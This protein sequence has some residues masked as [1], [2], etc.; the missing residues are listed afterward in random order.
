MTGPIERYVRVA[1]DIPGAS[2][3]VDGTVELGLHY[4]EGQ[5]PSMLRPA[6][7][8]LGTDAALYFGGLALD[9]D[10]ADQ[11][12]RWLDAR[13]VRQFG[14]VPRFIEVWRGTGADAEPLTQWYAPH[15]MPVRP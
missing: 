2:G 15:G 10:R 7:E 4:D 11:V 9:E 1:V 6:L 5:K 14:D 13:L 12:T 8:Q 3:R